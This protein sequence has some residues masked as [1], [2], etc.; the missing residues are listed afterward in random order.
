[1][2]LKMYYKAKYLLFLLCLVK[3]GNTNGVT[4]E[5]IEQKNQTIMLP[6]ADNINKVMPQFFHGE[7]TVIISTEKVSFAGFKH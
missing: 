1:M 4:E 7:Y 2:E 6:D 5:R 3:R